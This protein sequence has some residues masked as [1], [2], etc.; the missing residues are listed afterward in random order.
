[1]Y[2]LKVFMEYYIIITEPENKITQRYIL[3]NV[4][5]AFL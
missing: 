2:L 5:I 4:I 1:M 3:Y